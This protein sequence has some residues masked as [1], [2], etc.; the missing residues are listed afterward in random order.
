[1]AGMK[2]TVLVLFVCCITPPS[3]FSQ[4]AKRPPAPEKTG[5]YQIL[6]TESGDGVGYFKIV[7]L[8]DTATGITWKYEPAGSYT[9]PNGKQQATSAGRWVKVDF[10]PGDKSAPAR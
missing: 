9:D 1:M 5:R 8:L 10:L 2:L 4:Q 6:T 3:L 7:F